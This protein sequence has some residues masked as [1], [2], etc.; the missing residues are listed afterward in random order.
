MF[1]FFMWN[2]NPVSLLLHVGWLFVA[3]FTKLL[4]ISP[5]VLAVAPEVP[6]S[7]GGPTWNELSIFCTFLSL[8]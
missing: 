6:V 8:Y 1:Y 3:L 2:Q 7:S 4:N 5:I